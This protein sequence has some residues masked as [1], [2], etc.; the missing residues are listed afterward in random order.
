MKRNDPDYEFHH[1]R[2]PAKRDHVAIVLKAFIVVLILLALALLYLAVAEHYRTRF[3]PDTYVNGTDIS[4]MTH[5]EAENALP[6]ELSTFTITNGGEE[7]D[8]F[9]LTDIGGAYCFDHQLSAI[10]K[11]QHASRWLFSLSR[12]D[13]DEVPDI[14]YDETKVAAIVEA[15]DCVN[16]PDATEPENAYYE[17][18]DTGFDVVPEKTGTAIDA[19]LLTS[20]IRIALKNGEYT[21][22]AQN[23]LKQPTVTADDLPLTDTM[24]A[25]NAYDS[26]PIDM[27]GGAV[28]TIDKATV[29]GWLVLADD[30]TVTVDSSAVAGTVAE[31]AQKYNTLGTVRTF[32]THSGQ[33]IQVGGSEKDTMGYEMDQETTTQ[34]LAAAALTGSPTSA[35]WPVAGFTRTDENDFGSTYVEVSIYDQHLWYYV[36]GVVTLETD[37]V[38]G[39]GV[40]STTPGVFMILDKQSPATLSGTGYETKVSY[41]MPVTYSGTGLHDATWRTSFGKEIYVSGGSH[42]CVNMPLEK[43]EELYNSIDMG[44]PV[45]IYN[46]DV[47]NVIEEEGDTDAE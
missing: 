44:T 15:L 26:L 9:A 6:Y 29:M 28:E 11:Q 16:D 10:L 3:L 20:E 2:T 34:R 4:G 46:Q 27:S 32:T 22:D 40:N 24:Q 33:K 25:V 45:I 1:A 21:A 42:G 5:D 37:V 39:E 35:R 43:A 47:G 18:T 7:V 30:G 12:K 8:S 17:K 41:W 31:L 36:D 13:Y 23:C 19:D 14:T 38:T